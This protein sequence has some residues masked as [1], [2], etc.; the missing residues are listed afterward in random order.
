[1]QFFNTSYL[2]PKIILGLICLE[3]GL[4]RIALGLL[5]QMIIFSTSSV[6]GLRLFQDRL[7]Y[8]TGVN[9]CNMSIS[10]NV[11]GLTGNFYGSTP[12][13]SKNIGL[14]FH[15]IDAEESTPNLLY[16]FKLKL[17]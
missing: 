9:S 13:T 10:S 12:K 4:T 8:K 5:L 14:Q 3:L 6:L 2:L 11:I 17:I 16:F 15:L 7:L 1:M